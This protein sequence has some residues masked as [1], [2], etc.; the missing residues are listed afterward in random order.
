MLETFSLFVAWVVT[1][2]N[3]VGVSIPQWV[4]RKDEHPKHDF[5]GRRQVG[6]LE[7]PSE[8][9]IMSYHYMPN[10]HIIQ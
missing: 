2:L 5:G 8:V 1:F 6:L 10:R 7:Y 9:S 4:K 3:I